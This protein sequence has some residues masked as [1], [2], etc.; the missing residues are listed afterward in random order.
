MNTAARAFRFPCGA[1][2][3]LVRSDSRATV[4]LDRRAVDA[5]GAKVDFLAVV[6]EVT[7]VPWKLESLTVGWPPQV[8]LKRCDDAEEAALHELFTF[9]G[10]KRLLRYGYGTS[11]GITELNGLAERVDA[12]RDRLFLAMAKLPARAPIA[13]WLRKLE[14]ASHEL[15]TN[16]YKARA[17]EGP[18]P[19]ASEI[20]PAV[21]E[22]REAYALVGAH[23]DAVYKL[24]AAGNLTDQI[25]K[26]LRTGHGAP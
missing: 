4:Q 3:L 26:D 9:L 2:P 25:R 23:V 8:V 5:A 14:E 22:L 6:W 7:S 15:L 11:A 12:I 21:D 16:A 24:P 1:L 18:A 10:G 17:S 19:P 13:E 20:A